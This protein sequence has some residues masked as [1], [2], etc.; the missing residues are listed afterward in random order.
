M[1]T[2]FFHA[3]KS[4]GLPV[5]LKE[6][7]ALLEGLQADV[8]QR[9]VEDFY[10]LSRAC[11]VKDERHLDRFDRVF[12]QVFKGLEALPE[13]VEAEIPEEWLR[14]VSELHLSEEDK[15]RIAELGGWEKIMETLRKR[16]EEQK[17][18]HAGG[19]KWIGTG[20]TS[21]YGAYGYNP[22]GVRIGQHESRHRRAIK[23][24]D[25]REFR[26]LDET[27]ELGTRNIKVALRRLRMF[28]RQGSAEELDLA[29]TI[30]GT[31][32][33][34]YLDIRMVPERHNAVKVL[35]FFDVGGSMDWHVKGAEELFSAAR[36]EFKHLEY[37]YFHNCLYEEV[38]RHNAR[39]A[40]ER[41]PTWDVL[42]TYPADYKVIIIGDASMSPYEITHAGGSVEHMNEEAG[43]AWL[44]RVTGTY[45][46]CVWL[47]PIPEQHWGWTQS[48]GMVRKLM[49][50]RMYPLTLGGLDSAIGEL[51]R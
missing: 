43:A 24:W 2:T 33:K 18:R 39:R 38:W 5:T 28:A 26:D 25:K 20:G 41:T 44:G 1:F 51:M 21:P 50:G 19:S 27:V 8:A 7:L 16:L 31:A 45:K 47:N 12:G 4:A 32:E 15:K 3:L 11:L 35:M 37:Y 48:V 14:L 36:S 34:G 10:F 6:Y 9:R 17:E 29:G 42:N 49:G 46:H 13:G 30:R 40:S 23:V 22:A